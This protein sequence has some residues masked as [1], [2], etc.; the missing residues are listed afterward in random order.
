M[1]TD[2]AVLPTLPETALV[3]YD[4]GF[5]KEKPVTWEPVSADQVGRYHTFTV[6]GHIEGIDQKA[7][8]KVTVEG[9]IAVE[10]VSVTTPVGERPALPESVRAYHSNGKS[11]AAK[12]VWD[13]VNP[14]QFAQEGNLF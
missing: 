6:K 4:K 14:Q 3:E 8:A 12:V 10:E 11:F 9:I 2:R 13:Q 5:P 7:E 1:S